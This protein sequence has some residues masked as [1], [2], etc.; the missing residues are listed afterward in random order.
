MDKQAYAV[1]V[2]PPHSQQ[3]EVMAVLA[4]DPVSAI[5]CAAKICAQRHQGHT[6]VVGVL[7]RSDLAS[8][9]NMLERCE[10][11]GPG[12]G[13]VPPDVDVGNLSNS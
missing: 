12:N 10:F 8:I 9:D 1:L 2:I 5:E 11:I 6:P 3:L 7:S 13:F 4:T